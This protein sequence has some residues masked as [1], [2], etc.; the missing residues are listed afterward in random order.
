MEEPCHGGPDAAGET[1]LAVE[2]LELGQT[3]F[4]TLVEGTVRSDTPENQLVV[5]PQ[6][7]RSAVGEFFSAL[8]L[9]LGLDEGHS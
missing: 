8:R 9:L 2:V 7:A 5:D 3:L 6:E 4:E 1:R